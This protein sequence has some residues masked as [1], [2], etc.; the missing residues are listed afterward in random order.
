MRVFEFVFV[1]PCVGECV[2]TPCMVM[3]VCVSFGV[4]ECIW[5]CVL[6]CFW[7]CV[8]LRLCCCVFARVMVA[9]CPFVC[10]WLYVPV[11]VVVSTQVMYVREQL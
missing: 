4:Y 2:F 9:G 11:C 3:C 6:T 10:G 8:L 5:V 7:V 1:V